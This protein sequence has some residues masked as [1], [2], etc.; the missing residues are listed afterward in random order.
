MDFP[1]IGALQAFGGAYD[2]FVSELAASG[3]SILFSTFYGGS[4][5]DSATAITL[6]QS[7]NVYVGGQTSSRD[8]SVYAAVQSQ[9]SSQATGWVMRLGSA[10][11]APPTNVS[12]APSSGTAAAG[13]SQTFT[14]TFGD[15]SGAANITWIQADFGASLSTVNSC[16]F[17]LGTAAPYPLTLM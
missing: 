1:Q 16:F 11:P 13:Q 10:A 12:V 15:T 9:N 6:D 8:F 4:G 3:S 14:F 2:A 7:A 5:S 17:I